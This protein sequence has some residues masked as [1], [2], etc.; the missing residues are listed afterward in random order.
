MIAR[1]IAKYLSNIITELVNSNTE[2]HRNVKACKHMIVSI[3]LMCCLVGLGRAY[4]GRYLGG[5]F[6]CLGDMCVVFWEG[7]LGKHVGK[8]YRTKQIN[9]HVCF[10]F[11]LDV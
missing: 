10:M 2:K 8:M 6:G 3:C 9:K 4:L 7:C 11:S 1:N 5:V